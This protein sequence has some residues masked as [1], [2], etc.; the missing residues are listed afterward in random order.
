M[1]RRSFAVID[2]VEVLEHWYAGRPKLAVAESLGVDRKTIRKYV[3]PAEEAGFAPGGPPV[4]TEEWAL[5]VR[6]WFPDLAS[7]SASLRHVRR[8]R[9]ASRGHQGSTGHQPPLHRPPAPAR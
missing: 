6:S 3:A 9:G 8:V 4:T 5:Y 2:I 1:V 7:P